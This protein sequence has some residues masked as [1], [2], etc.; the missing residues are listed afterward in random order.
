MSVTPIKLWS[1]LQV[2]T[3]AAAEAQI[4]QNDKKCQDS[5]EFRN[6]HVAEIQ[7]SQD[8]SNKHKL[9]NTAKTND[10][11]T[12]KSKTFQFSVFANKQFAVKQ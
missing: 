12:V 9:M 4:P 1:R 7:A 10:K 2:I 11:D 5:E 3:A 8:E 6:M